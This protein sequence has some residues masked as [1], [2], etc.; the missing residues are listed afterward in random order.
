MA[1]IFRRWFLWGLLCAA[2]IAGLVYAFWPQPVPVDLGEVSRGP[3]EV[4]VDEE[5]ETRVKDV[6]VVS[7]PLPGRLMR[8]ESEVGDWVNA[9]EKVLAT[10]QPAD[11]EFLDVRSQVEREAGRSRIG[12]SECG[13]QFCPERPRSS[14]AAIRAR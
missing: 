6:Y 2:L 3:L 1:R 9:R 10:I 12:A 8:I 5:G 13:A 11:P 4:T 14:G 7:A